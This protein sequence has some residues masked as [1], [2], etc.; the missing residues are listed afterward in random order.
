MKKI[1]ALLIALLMV[2]AL[3]ACGEK[4]PQK[5]EDVKG[6][7]RETSLMSA[8]VPKGWKAFGKADVFD[9]FPDEDGDPSGLRI[10]K[11]AEAEYDAYSKPGIMIDYYADSDTTLADTE[12]WYENVQ[13]FDP[14]TIGK[15]TWEGYNAESLDTPVVILM[16]DGGSGKIQVALT[17]E[18]S[19][20]KI[21]LEDVDVQ[22]IIASITIK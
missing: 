20:G 10:Y 18:A 16:T 14:I 3:A 2:V 4:E 13:Y 8:L 5:P 12:F 9:E 6:E 22:A 7:T 19:D 1:A 17:L 21:A 11:G 15:Y